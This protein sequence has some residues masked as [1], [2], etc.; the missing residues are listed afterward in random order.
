MSETNFGGPYVQVAT[1]C[2]MPLVDNTG[3]L[4]VIRMIDRIPVGGPTDEMQPTPL[5]QLWLVLVLKSGDMKGVKCTLA[6]TP[7]TPSGKRLPP[8][9][10]GVLFEGDERGTITMTPL[11]LVAEEEGLYWFEITVENSVL[12]RI[13]LRVMYQK[14]QRMPGMPFQP[15]QAG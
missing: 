2:A 3:L 1:I 8:A 14:V 12:T 10:A 11:A 13:P 6:I 4:S 9:Q 5:H 15:P 7:I